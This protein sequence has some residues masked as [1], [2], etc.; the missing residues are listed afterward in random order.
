MERRIGWEKLRG[1]DSMK[2]KI[3]NQIIIKRSEDSGRRPGVNFLNDWLTLNA[4]E[5]KLWKT[6]FRM[7]EKMRVGLEREKG[8]PKTLSEYSEQVLGDESGDGRI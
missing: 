7:A 4:L 2:K 8:G 6:L 5:K 1:T 3:K